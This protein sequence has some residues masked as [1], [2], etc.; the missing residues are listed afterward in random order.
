[1]KY[2]CI[3]DYPGREPAAL[4][5]RKNAYQCA[6]ARKQEPGV[7]FSTREDAER[8]AAEVS[9]VTKFQWTVKEVDL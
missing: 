2:F 7:L 3:P 8:R 6:Q 4:M 9:A 1:M 5:K